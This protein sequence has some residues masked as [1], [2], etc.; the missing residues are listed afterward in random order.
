MYDQG[1]N[2]QLI[3]AAKADDPFAVRKALAEGADINIMET[4]FGFTALCIAA[5]NGNAEIV[6][7]LVDK[8]AEVDV[9]SNDGSTAM[10][11]AA[12][13]VL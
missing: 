5:Q 11:V 2:D 3:E 6:K 10:T 1:K 13:K 7:L 9:P 12:Q 4:N 8:N